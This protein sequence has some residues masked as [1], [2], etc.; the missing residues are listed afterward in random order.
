MGYG[1]GR[2]EKK[3]CG[4]SSLRKG[5]RVIAAALE[6]AVVERLTDH[7]PDTLGGETLLPADLVIG[8]SVA[9]PHE[10]A[11]GGRGSGRDVQPSPGRYDRIHWRVRSI[12]NAEKVAR[13]SGGRKEIALKDGK[14]GGAAN[15]KP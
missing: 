13:G 8:P 5:A 15:G 1:R 11:L 4:S 7:P 14:R 6:K 10:N 9:P 12:P 3:S 2:G